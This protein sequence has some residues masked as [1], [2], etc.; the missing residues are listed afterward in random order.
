MLYEVITYPYNSY[1]SSNYYYRT[2]SLQI[3]SSPAGA[4]VYLNNKYRGKTPHTGYL[5]I[6]SLQPGTYD[7]LIQYD[8][9]L[10][11]TSTIY[12]ERGQV[13]TVNVVL[14]PEAGPGSRI[15]SYNVCYTKLLRTRP[16]CTPSTFGL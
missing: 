8:D 14:T 10:P 2:S 12:V 1:Y 3:L 5:E 16:N 9:Y 7:L 15:T 4:T 11:Y 6:S 13:R